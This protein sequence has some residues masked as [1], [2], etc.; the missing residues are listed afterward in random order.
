MGAT[1][2]FEQ[3]A[4]DG[5]M[6]KDLTSPLLLFGASKLINDILYFPLSSSSILLSCFIMYLLS[7]KN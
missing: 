2:I 1:V 6:L 4:G 5:M 7:Y 3:T